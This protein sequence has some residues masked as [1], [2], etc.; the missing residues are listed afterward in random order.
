MKF[1][2]L[3]DNMLYMK[4]ED[5]TQLMYYCK[6]CNFSTIEDDTNLAQPLMDTVLNPTST[7]TRAF[8]DKSIKHDVTLP[9]VS[10]ITCKNPNCIKKPDEENEVIYMKH[11]NVNMNFLYFCCKCE[12][13]F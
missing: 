10:N 12:T 4:T 2:Q 3:C 9:R 13:F 6:N 7:A 8:I 1:C 5:N 11:D